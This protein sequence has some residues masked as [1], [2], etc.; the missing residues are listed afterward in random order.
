MRPLLAVGRIPQ[1]AIIKQGHL[2]RIPP[3]LESGTVPP[4]FVKIPEST[5]QFLGES[6]VGGVLVSVNEK[7]QFIL[8]L[9]AFT[10][11]AVIQV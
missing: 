6:G 9:R 2:H 8:L 1:M 10:V 3:R 11:P 4:P 5:P 7:T